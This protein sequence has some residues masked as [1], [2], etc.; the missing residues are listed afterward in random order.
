[1]NVSTGGYGIGT[2]PAY[3]AEPEFI[4]ALL[5]GSLLSWVLKR[6]S[7]AWRGGWFEAR[8]GN[9]ERL[10]LA[11]PDGKRQTEVI[12]LYR[13]VR[14][15]VAAALRSPDDHDAVRLSATA[16]ATFDHAI[17]ALYGL[18]LA[19]THLVSGV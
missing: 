10:P 19:E 2:D 15:A 1:V 5:N 18:T 16:R 6:Y 13:Q 4:A 3:G 17:F 8:K 14:A 11:I 9:L 7:R 12:D